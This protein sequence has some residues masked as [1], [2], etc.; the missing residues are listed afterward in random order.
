MMGRCVADV[1]LRRMGGGGKKGRA[2]C[3][4]VVVRR[5]AADVNAQQ[6][7]GER[8]AVDGDGQRSAPLEGR[9]DKLDRMSRQIWKRWKLFRLRRLGFAE[10]GVKRE[11]RVAV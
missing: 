7:A 5:R 2:E 6:S 9:G 1:W 8:D 11:K 3:L 4:A 10:G